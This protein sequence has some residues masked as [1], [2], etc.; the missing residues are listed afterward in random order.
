MELSKMGK[1]ELRATC[2]DAKVKGYGKLTVAG[3]R[4]ALAQLDTRVLADTFPMPAAKTKPAKVTREEVMEATA[5]MQPTRE[6]K[7]TQA[8]KKAAAPKPEREERNGVRAPLPGPGAC[9]RVWS[10]CAELHAAGKLDWPTLRAWSGENGLTRSNSS[11]ELSVFTASPDRR[12][13]RRR[14]P[15][16]YQA[17]LSRG[18]S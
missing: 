16:P 15:A 18:F 6:R 3:M 2:R 13:P 7:P 12:K 8:A 10:K 5:R 4:E 14:H 1:T 9:A 11:Q 17:P